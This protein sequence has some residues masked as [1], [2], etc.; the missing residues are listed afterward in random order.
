MAII[1][2]LALYDGGSVTSGD[3]NGDG[4]SD[5]VAL[6]NRKLYVIL[7]QASGWHATLSLATLN[8]T[9]GF[10]ISSGLPYADQ[11]GFWVNNAGDFN[12]DGIDDL[13]VG[14]PLT[15][16]SSDIKL[17]GAGYVLFGQTG[18]FPAILNLSNLN[19]T[20]G[21]IVE[22]L[23]A[24]DVLGYFVSTAGD[25]NGDGKADLTILSVRGQTLSKG[26]VIFG[27]ASGMPSHFNLTTLNG[28]N[29]FKIPGD[30]LFIDQ[31]PT[32]GDINGDGKDDLVIGCNLDQDFVIFGQ[33]SGQKVNR[34]PIVVHA[35][36]DQPIEVGTPFN[37]K[38][39][40]DTFVDPDAECLTYSAQ[41]ADGS[42]LPSWVSFDAKSLFFSGVASLAGNTS[43]SVE[44][45][46]TDSLSI[47]ANFGLLAT[48]MIS[49]SPSNPLTPSNTPSIS[50]GIFVG[51]IIGGVAGGFACAMA[52]GAY[53]AKKR[54]FF[55]KLYKN[56]DKEY[57]LNKM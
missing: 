30:N 27:Q 48:Q 18:P 28:I 25:L 17:S 13:A 23:A 14:A 50:L 43:L 31:L 37:F 38:I 19:G 36:P 4:K 54:G 34:P 8:G 51:G 21:F 16:R 56:L 44:A 57:T 55:A 1:E 52:I 39:A 45:T 29:G 32:A 47:R 24:N 49:P 46:D 26:Y 2:G 42:P 35:I 53:L 6:D 22:G 41:Q 11:F 9:N 3:F 10:A 40:S 5:L 20:N 15:G 7:G 33:A 12:G